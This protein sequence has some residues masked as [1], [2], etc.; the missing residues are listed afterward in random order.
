M[1]AYI[2]TY[3]FFL[4]QTLLQVFILDNASRVSRAFHCIHS[5]CEL[6]F[7]VGDAVYTSKLCMHIG[8]SQQRERY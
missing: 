1:P 4:A 8:E 5:G 2:P 6:E 3:F 7:I